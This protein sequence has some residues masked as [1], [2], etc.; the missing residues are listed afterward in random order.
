MRRLSGFEFRRSRLYT[1]APLGDRSTTQG[2]APPWS[3]V[4]RRPLSARTD[5]VANLGSGD[6]SAVRAKCRRMVSDHV[7]RNGRL[8]LILA[9]SVGHRQLSISRSAHLQD[10][11]VGGAS[12]GNDRASAVRADLSKLSGVVE[13]SRVTSGTDPACSRRRSRVRVPSLPSLTF[14]H[15]VS[16]LLP[17]SR[18]SLFELFALSMWRRCRDVGPRFPPSPPLAL[19]FSVSRAPR[20]RAHPVRRLPGAASSRSCS[21]RRSSSTRWTRRSRTRR[22]RGRCST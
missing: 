13:W 21:R 7:R 4:R 3:D 5:C 12:A 6:A 19:Q 22:R 14:S 11:Y 18:T 8:W 10:F 1:P 2:Q 17:G 20:P 15:Q 16:V 9:A